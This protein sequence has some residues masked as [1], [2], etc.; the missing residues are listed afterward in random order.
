MGKGILTLAIILI[1][2]GVITIAFEGLVE[3]RAK[4]YKTA[5]LFLLAEV[6]YLIVVFGFYYPIWLAFMS[7]AIGG[8]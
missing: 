6:T 1:I 5:L 2:I 7:N 8:V 4:R 3:W